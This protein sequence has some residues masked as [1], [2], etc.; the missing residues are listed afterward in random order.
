MIFRALSV[1]EMHDIYFA[2]MI[3]QFPDS[4]RRTWSNIER[5]F[6]RGLYAAY[7]LF[8]DDSI[9]AYGTCASLPGGHDMILD[10]LAVPDVW[11]NRGYGSMFLKRLQSVIPNTDRILVETED[12]DV[13]QDEQRDIAK[14]RLG[15]Y[16]R[17][18]FLESNVLIDLFSVQYRLYFYGG[19]NNTDSGLITA[20][21]AIYRALQP[22]EL[23]KKHVRLWIA[24]EE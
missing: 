6:E 9:R 4:E 11:K 2:D 14:R 21:D 10:Y 3:H 1:Q 13:L 7:G 18:G 22:P 17:N 20:A 23:Y 12:P 15:F 19:T 16:A 5:L 8:E 24:K